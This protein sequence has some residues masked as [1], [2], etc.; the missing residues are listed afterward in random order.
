MAYYSLQ[1]H[2]K[3]FS[4]YIVVCMLRFIF[5]LFSL[6][7]SSFFFF[8]P[9]IFLLKAISLV[10]SVKGWIWSF[11]SKHRLV[12]NIMNSLKKEGGNPMKIPYS[13]GLGDLFF[14]TA[15]W[16]AWFCHFIL[17][18]ILLCLH[19]NHRYLYLPFDFYFSH[20]LLSFRYL[21]E[22]QIEM[23]L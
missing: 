10:L 4:M 16:I 7:S 17:V 12:F 5:S 9:P 19:D 8:S 13:F 21:W 18:V 6:T 2:L 15:P 20:V 3:R 1:I 22:K 23:N 11:R 14:Q